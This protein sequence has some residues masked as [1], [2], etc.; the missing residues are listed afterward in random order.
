M[1]KDFEPR[2]GTYR[3]GVRTGRKVQQAYVQQRTIAWY[4]LG[5]LLGHDIGVRNVDHCDNRRRKAMADAMFHWAELKRNLALVVESEHDMEDAVR[6]A[7]DHS[8]WKTGKY[9]KPQPIMPD[10]TKQFDKTVK[11]MKAESHS[12]FQ[13][14]IS[15]PPER[16]KQT[17]D[18]PAWAKLGYFWLLDDKDKPLPASR[19]LGEE[20]DFNVKW[21]PDKAK[22][23]NREGGNRN[24]NKGGGG[25]Q[26]Q[27]GRKGD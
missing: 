26:N 25:N 13:R 8:A 23:R 7:G 10:C 20:T 9:I 14:I 1:W 5:W 21:D 22:Q 12:I 16:G 11:R 19:L 27:P 6:Y 4:L 18:T 17:L 2:R 15:P 24:R 3:I